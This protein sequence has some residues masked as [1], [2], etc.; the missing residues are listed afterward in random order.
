MTFFIAIFILNPKKKKKAFKCKLVV[1]L[2][3]D[4]GVYGNIVSCMPLDYKNS[5]KSLLQ[6]LKIIE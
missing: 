4:K 5:V 1:L 6:S 2:E 3:F